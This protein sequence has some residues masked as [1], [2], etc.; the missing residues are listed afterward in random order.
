MI[1]VTE[2]CVRT[3][4]NLYTASRCS[5]WEMIAASLSTGQYLVQVWKKCETDVAMYCKKAG[6]MGVSNPYVYCSLHCDREYLIRNVF[7]FLTKKYSP[8]VMSLPWVN[9]SV[10]E[11]EAKG[12]DCVSLRYVAFSESCKR[13]RQLCYCSTCLLQTSCQLRA[14]QP[15]LS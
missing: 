13:L 10:P 5:I 9:R 1:N 12:R 4:S 7:C 2:R 8:S 6:I 14:W 3:V 11:T 15:S